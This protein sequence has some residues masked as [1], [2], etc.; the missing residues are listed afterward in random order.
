[1]EAGDVGNPGKD[2]VEALGD[3]LHE[4]TLERAEEH[5]DGVGGEDE[6]HAPIGE[7]EGG[8]G[9]E[10]G[11]KRFGGVEEATSFKM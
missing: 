4:E 3:V 9:D 7:E 1:M 6:D 8:V 2:P 11:K 5:A 10:G